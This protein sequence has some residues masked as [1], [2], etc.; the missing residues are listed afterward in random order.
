MFLTSNYELITSLWLSWLL[1]GV[2]G[3][4]IYFIPN[5]SP[6]ISKLFRRPHPNWKLSKRWLHCQFHYCFACHCRLQP[7]HCP[8]H[9]DCSFFPS[10]HCNKH[11]RWGRDRECAGDFFERLWMDEFLS[12]CN[13]GYWPWGSEGVSKTARDSF[14]D[15]ENQYFLQLHRLLSSFTKLDYVANV[16]DLT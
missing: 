14:C 1:L 11:R 10:P 5:P 2:F 8:P 15:E 9:L 7:R 13:Y 12:G 16:A 6:I 3:S 4:S